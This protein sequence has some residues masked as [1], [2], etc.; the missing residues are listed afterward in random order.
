MYCRG[1]NRINL[2][3]RVRV[4]TGGKAH[5]PQGMIRCNSGADST[6][7]M[8]EDGETK[9]GYGARRRAVF[10]VREIGLW[11]I[12]RTSGAFF[13]WRGR[14]RPIK[15]AGISRWIDLSYPSF[16]QGAQAARHPVFC[17][18]RKEKA[19]ENPWESPGKIPKESPEKN[20]RETPGGKGKRGGKNG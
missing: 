20:R 18:C 4:P 19:G 6:V 3:G 14:L 8:E 13:L 7:W 15:G 12:E 11:M 2:Q 10:C 5:E 17:F 1:E 16:G 9:S